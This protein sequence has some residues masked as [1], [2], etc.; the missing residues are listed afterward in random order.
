MK[1]STYLEPNKHHEYV[2]AQDCFML[3]NKLYHKLCGIT[4]INQAG[5][6]INFI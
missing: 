4:V 3:G 2:P 6:T 1:S 5:S